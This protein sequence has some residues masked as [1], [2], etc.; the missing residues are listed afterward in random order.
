MADTLRNISGMDAADQMALARD[1]WKIAETVTRNQRL[2]ELDDRR[3]VSGDQWP[4]DIKSIREREGLP[5]LVMNRVQGSVSRVANEARQLRPMIRITPVDS[6]ADP[7]TARILQGIIRHAEVQSHSDDAYETAT[8]S[9]AIGGRGFFQL[10]TTRNHRTLYEEL[11]FRRIRN[12]LRVRPDPYA[13]ELDYSD[14][15]WCFVTTR[16]SR[17]EFAT[18][19]PDA[20]ANLQS[21]VSGD[22]EE[23]ITPDFVR[24]AEY[25]YRE[26]VRV[27]RAR[28]PDG[29][30][31]DVEPEGNETQEQAQERIDALKGERF[32]VDMPKVWHQHINGFQVLDEAPFPADWI[33]IIPILGEEIDVDGDVHYSGVTRAAKDPQ[34][35]YNYNKSSIAATISLAPKAPFVMA[36]GQQ[37]GYERMWSEANRNMSPYLL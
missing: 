26:I 7:E 5:C 2:R 11:R 6:S 36:E 3:F 25:Y 33:P 35:Y 9:A 28:L 30:T 10:Y 16:M 8:I 23:W 31:I 21:F 13:N 24:V 4:S 12:P 1:R 18:R 37:Q 29:T 14:M 34:R 15:N 20:E 27:E 22:E 32:T 17:R 19:W